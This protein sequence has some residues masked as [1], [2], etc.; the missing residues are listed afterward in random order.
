MSHRNPHRPVIYVDGW[1]ADHIG[2]MQL[3]ILA[4]RLADIGQMEVDV[5]TH[6]TS[7]FHGDRRY[8]GGVKRPAEPENDE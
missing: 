2:G 1:F 5:L 6:G 3:K 8:V 7:E 4:E